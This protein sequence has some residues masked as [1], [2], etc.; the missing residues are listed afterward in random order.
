MGIAG[1]YRKLE[2]RQQ[3]S[4]GAGA[5]GSDAR[6]TSS[7]SKGRQLPVRASFFSALAMPSAH[8]R[9]ESVLSVPQMWLV[10]EPQLSLDRRETEGGNL[11]RVTVGHRKIHGGVRQGQWVTPSS[12]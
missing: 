6:S 10:V 3:A 1:C 12:S 5:R 8:V 2:T 4:M 11:K 9:K 7:P